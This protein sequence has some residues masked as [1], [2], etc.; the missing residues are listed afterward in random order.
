MKEEKTQAYYT[1]NGKRASLLW[2]TWEDKTN[3]TE[4]LLHY[5]RNTMNG[6][7]LMWVK[8]NGKLIYKAKATKP[9]GDER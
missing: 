6:E 7:T 9:K 5:M 2:T 3:R 8:R 1:L 4:I